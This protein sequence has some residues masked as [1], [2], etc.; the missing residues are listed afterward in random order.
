MEGSHVVQG[1]V[2]YDDGF[3]PEMEQSFGDLRFGGG[4]PPPRRK[5]ASIPDGPLGSKQQ[6]CVPFGRVRWHSP[7]NPEARVDLLQAPVLSYQFRGDSAMDKKQVPQLEKDG[8]ASQP[9]PEFR[10]R[11]EEFRLGWQALDGPGVFRIQV[12]EIT[13]GHHG[14]VI[15]RKDMDPSALFPGGSF[16]GP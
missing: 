15:A 11:T 3:D 7:D 2:A 16:E 12:P 5:K 9:A 1:G 13:G 6:R 10:F 4:W 8:T 14:F